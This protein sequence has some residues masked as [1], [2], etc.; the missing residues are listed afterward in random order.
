MILK[1]YCVPSIVLGHRDSTMN[2][3]QLLLLG[4]LCFVGEID[5]QI[6]K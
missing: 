6:N 1:D 4:S 2:K 3:T 5:K